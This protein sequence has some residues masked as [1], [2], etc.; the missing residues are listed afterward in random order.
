[1]TEIITPFFDFFSTV[2][3]RLYSFIVVT[4]ETNTVFKL[5]IILFF[6]A[7][8]LY[9]LLYMLLCYVNDFKISEYKFSIPKLFKRIKILNY[10]EK[11]KAIYQAKLDSIKKYQSDPKNK[12][13]DYVRGNYK[14]EL[15]FITHPYSDTF[16]YR[17]FRYDKER[18]EAHKEM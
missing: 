10:E 12:Y 11:Q 4:M 8:F 9:L 3:V 16:Y 17:G 15:Y 7:P 2:F 14:A 18:I 5:I 1:M 13:H 6:F